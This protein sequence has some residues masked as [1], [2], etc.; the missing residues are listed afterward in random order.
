MIYNAVIDTMLQRK[1]VRKYTSQ[2]PSDEV[3]ETIVLAGQQAPFAYQMGSLLLSR[4]AKQHP[5]HAPLMF[6]ICVDSHRHEL[7]MA[8]RG[9]KMAM[10]DFSLLM[11]GIQDA[12]YMAENM[13]IAA[14][15]LGLG[16]CFIGSC[17]FEA[18]EII[19]QYQLPERVFPLVWL[20]MGYPAEDK[21][22]RPRYPLEFHLHEGSY[23]P[24]DEAVIEKAMRAMDEGYQAQ[25]YYHN[26]GLIDLENGRQETY[27]LKTYSWTEHISRKTG[28]WL[29][30]PE[31]LLRPLASCGFDLHGEHE[32]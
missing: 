20:V 9:W 25:R 2:M 1:S 26:A 4:D 23:A 13:V 14:E 16:S 30:K 18:E 7:V 15:S 10:N 29:R 12:A 8:H 32:E 22:P 11:F 21:P 28:Q 19:A 31:D 24:D 27:T 3:I 6:T 5:F 17:P